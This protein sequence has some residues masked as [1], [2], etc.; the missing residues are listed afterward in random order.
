M[1]DKKAYKAWLK[2]TRFYSDADSDVA[3]NAPDVYLPAAEGYRFKA[4]I[5]SE[6]ELLKFIC[7]FDSP[8]NWEEDEI[9]ELVPHE[10]DE[11]VIVD[12]MTF[13]YEDE[14]AEVDTMYFPAT[15]QITGKLFGYNQYFEDGKRIQCSQ[16][17]W[18]GYHPRNIQIIK[19]FQYP[20]LVSYCCEE[21]FDR[22]GDFRVR[23]IDI[24]ELGSMKE[25]QVHW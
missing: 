19:K 18:D 14:E 24:T 22:C 11:E 25:N 16:Y 15:T 12:E 6:E 8:R 4:L 10:D 7:K 21:G 20:I 5:T 17:T 2:T 23:S 3:L 1:N 13:Q 9:I